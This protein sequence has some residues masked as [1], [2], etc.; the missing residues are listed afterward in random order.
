[1]D[2]ID[3]MIDNTVASLEMEG[4]H[5]TESDKALMRRCVLGELSFD[6]AVKIV[7]DR[8]VS[9]NECFDR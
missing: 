9:S 2:R 5:A 4:L 7:L 8:Y 3:Y 1:M 6:D